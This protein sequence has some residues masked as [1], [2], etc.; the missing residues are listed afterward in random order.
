MAMKMKLAMKMTLAMA[1][2]MKMTMAMALAMKMT[3]AMA[4]AMKM[5]PYNVVCM[6]YFRSIQT[7]LF[8]TTIYQKCCIIFKIMYTDWTNT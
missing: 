7:F 6:N 2:A 1:M 4:M 8:I 3:M 5:Y